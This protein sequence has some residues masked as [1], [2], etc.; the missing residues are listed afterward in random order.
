[1]DKRGMWALSGD[2][3]LHS[4]FATGKTAGIFSGKPL[5]RFSSAVQPGSARLASQQTRFRPQTG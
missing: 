2:L 5:Q 3:W 1:M 4:L